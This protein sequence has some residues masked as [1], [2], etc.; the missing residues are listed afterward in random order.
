MGF[1]SIADLGSQRERE[2]EA[3]SSPA[4]GDLRDYTQDLL[5]LRKLFMN[6]EY[7]EVKSLTQSWL[8]EMPSE[9]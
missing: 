6:G 2:E 5:N 9:S 7:K 3:V 8:K 4:K 1:K